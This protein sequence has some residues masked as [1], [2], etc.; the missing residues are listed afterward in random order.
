MTKAALFASLMVLTSA[1]PAAP[2]V[3]QQLPSRPPVDLNEKVC[4]DIVYT[5]SRLGVKRVCGT[6]AE[7]AERRRLDK[8]AIDRAQ[9]SPCT[10]TTTGGTGR[11]SC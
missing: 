7:W 3:A 10:I 6:R 8:E 2:A 4:E 11:P 9:I 5:G 1:L